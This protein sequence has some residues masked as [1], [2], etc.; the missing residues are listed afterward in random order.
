MT[1]QITPDTGT[2]APTHPRGG[3]PPWRAARIAGFSYLVMFALGIFANFTVMEGLVEPGDAAATLVNMTESAGLLRWG[4]LAFL[5]IVVLDLV[6]A[7]A[8]NVVFRGVDRDISLAAAWSR[9]A[10]TVM[11]GVGLASLARVPGL[12][13]GPSYLEAERV[14]AEVMA[15]VEAFDLAWMIGLA[16]FGVHLAL[17][18]V[19]VARSGLVTRALGWILVVAGVAYLADAVANLILPDYEAVAGV[20]LVVVAVPSMVGEGWLGLWLAFTRRLGR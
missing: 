1:A 15:S 7:W 19:L 8:L 4:L 9:L 16:L 5:V 13:A 14:A 11:L 12:V 18:G 10:Y 6:I 2:A 17:L 20:L 3:F